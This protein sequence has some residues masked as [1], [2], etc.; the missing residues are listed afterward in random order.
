MKIR[1]PATAKAVLDALHAKGYEAYVVGGCVRD[2]VLGKMPADWDITTN[3]RPEQVKQ[4]FARTVD[5]GIKHGTV[6]VL[7]GSRQHEVTTY[8]IDGSYSDGRHPDKVTFTPSLA[9]DLKR[10]DFTINAMAYNEEEGLIDLFGGMDDLQNKLIR[11]VGD[12]MERFSEDALRI[13]RAVRFSAQLNFGIDEQ[14]I[15][16]IVRLAPTLSRISAERICTE[17]VKLICSDHPEYLKVAYQAGITRVILPEFD[18]LMKTPQNN[19]HHIYDVGTHT[20]VSMMNVKPDKTLRLTMLMHDMGKPA[21][22]TTDENGV[23][24]FKGHAGVSADI[25]DKV[26]HRLKLDN[27]TIRTV[28]TLV[29]CHDYRIR[30]EKKLVR[31]LISSVGAEN[32]HRLICVQEADTLA[33]SEYQ[34]IEKLQN[35]MQVT[36]VGEKILQEKQALTVKDLAI[37]GRD[38]IEAGVP[39]GPAIGQILKGALDE[40]LDDQEK[41]TRAYLMAYAQNAYA[42]NVAGGKTGKNRKA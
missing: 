26:L 11:C 21:T 7:I 14:T 24:H 38:L 31:R 33:Q 20:L 35:I 16:G 10:R 19:P 34:R 22:R 36:Q 39:E 42:Q 40:V 17:L 9:E 15:A 41:N 32:F 2:S 18:A 3:A 29:R 5:T 37:T 27:D 4:I 13:L 8:R 23:D 6:T 12:P 25:A 30:P 28:T 1:I